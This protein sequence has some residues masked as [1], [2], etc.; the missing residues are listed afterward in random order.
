[1][2][3]IGRV[4]A[5]A[6]TICIIASVVS[7]EWSDNTM[8]EV[9]KDECNGKPWGTAGQFDFYVFEQSWSA[10]FCQTKP[11]YPGCKK[12]TD[13]MRTRVTI[14]G[15]WP[16]YNASQQGH[17]WPQCCPSQYGTAV[18]PQ[19]VRQYWNDLLTYWPNEQDPTPQSPYTGSLWEHEWA[20][21]GTCAGPDQATYF[22]RVLRSVYPQVPTPTILMQNVGGSV[23]KNALLSAYN[24]KVKFSCTNGY[25]GAIQSCFTKDYNWIDCPAAAGQDTCNVNTINI[26]AF[27]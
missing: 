12:P 14:H 18:N 11:Q 19:V 17:L 13:F 23:S 26:R 8:I 7:G 6:A 5:I 15:L 4:V 21:H 27:P 24:K 10:Q 25:L 1:M 9:G 22:G 16:N 3:T 20:K 2:N